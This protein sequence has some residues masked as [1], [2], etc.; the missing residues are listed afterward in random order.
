MN[1][2]SARAFYDLGAKRVVLAR[3]IGIDDISKIRSSVPDD[4]ELEAFCHGSMCVSFSGRCLLSSYLTGRDS[5]HGDCAQPCRWKYH[6]VEERR[7]GDYYEI[8]EDNGTFILNARDLC[9]IQRVKELMEA[10]VSSFKIEGRTKSA[11]YTASATAAYRHAIDAAK[12]GQALPKIWEDEVNKLSHRP[13]T[14][15]FYFG[16]PGQYC[17]SSSYFSDWDVVAMVE[18]CDSSGTACITQRNSFQIGDTVELFRW[19]V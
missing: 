19:P 6:L 2:A 13:Y 10:G 1:S 9:T 18:S 16:N 11:Y 5:N 15:G 4:L 3:E 12:S 8:T 17:S 7:P 14:E